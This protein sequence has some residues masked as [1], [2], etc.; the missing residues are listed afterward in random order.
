MKKTLTAALA[1]A[2][3]AVIPA[4]AALADAHETA[5]VTVVHGVPG[6]DGVSVLAGDDALLSGLDFGD[7]ATISVPAGT[8]DIAVSGSDSPDDIALGPVSLTFD[9][10]MSYAVTA[11]LDAEGNATASQFTVNNAEGI[12]VFHTA[13]FPDVAIIAGGEAAADDVANGDDLQL[14]LDA[15]TTLSD[16]GVAAAG[17]T[18]VLI[19]LG[20]VTIPEGQRILA[21]AIGDEDTIT[22]ETE[23]I[24]V[25]GAEEAEE[26]TEAPT[27]VDSGT[28]GLNTGLP[29][30]VAALM[31]IGALGLAVPAVATARRNS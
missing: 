30:W 17:T 9:A 10:G 16:V 2:A 29:M 1:A 7:I 6:L 28:G 27:S 20:D 12:S 26:D 19:P 23:V 11:N 3:L 18:E 22:V 4:S 5:Q 14:D 15:G 13:A 21:F 8:Y 25:L 31:A 24:D